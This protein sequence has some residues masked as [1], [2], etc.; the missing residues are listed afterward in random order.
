MGTVMAALIGRLGDNPGFHRKTGHDANPAPRGA[1]RAHAFPN[2]PAGI[3][4]R[5]F[6]L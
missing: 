2:S 6:D 5:S 1:T 3:T 4:L